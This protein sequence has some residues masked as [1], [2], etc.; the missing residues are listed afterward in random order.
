MRRWINGITI[1]AFLAAAVALGQTKTESSTKE[2]PGTMY[3]ESKTE[4]KGPGPNT[5]VKTETVIGTVKEYEAGKKITVTGPKDKDYTFSLDENV[6]MKGTVGVGE[7]VKVSYTRS[8]GGEK[9]TTV[10][11]RPSAR[12]AKKAKKTAA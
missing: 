9:V 11:A 10:V 3:V 1:L 2:K 8:D 4:H 5:K 6:V 7:R 12:S